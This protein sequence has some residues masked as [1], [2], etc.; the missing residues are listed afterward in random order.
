MVTRKP[1]TYHEM[2]Y[3]SDSEQ[4]RSNSIVIK[5]GHWPR[6]CADGVSLVAMLGLIRSFSYHPAWYDQ[7]CKHGNREQVG[8]EQLAWNW[9]YAIVFMRKGLWK[10]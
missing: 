6:P 1:L 9:E 2:T 3:N 7:K 4:R 8:I 5:S 10:L